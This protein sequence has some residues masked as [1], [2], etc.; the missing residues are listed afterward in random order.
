[1]LFYSFYAKIYKVMMPKNIDTEKDTEKNYDVL[2]Q[3]NTEL[4]AEAVFS[5]LE[6]AAQEN[7]LPHIDLD[8]ATTRET[9]FQAIVGLADNLF[10]QGSVE[11]AESFAKIVHPKLESIMEKLQKEAMHDPLTGALNRNGIEKF[12]DYLDEIGTTPQALIAVDLTNFKSI[13]DNISHLRGDEVLKEVSDILREG[14]VV[15]RIG[16]DEFVVVLWDDR[17]ESERTENITH[18]E[19]LNLVIDRISVR[20]K[21]FIDNNADLAN[22]KF[23]VAKGATVWDPDK[24][25]NEHIKIALDAMKVDKATQHEEN[26]KYR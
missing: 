11:D 1:M 7:V 5:Y 19:I 2:R 13:N 8:D 22:L 9:I 20:I 12:I 18:E 4:A 24:P 16:G 26:G 6:K 25:L 14:D 10:M 15:A 21:E 23:E 3:R 17:P